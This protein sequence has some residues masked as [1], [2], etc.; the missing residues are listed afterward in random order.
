MWEDKNREFVWISK[1]MFYHYLAEIT[2]PHLLVEIPVGKRRNWFTI[3]DNFVN[4]GTRCYQNTNKGQCSSTVSWIKQLVVGH[5]S[6]S[7][8]FYPRSIHVQSMV[9]KIFTDYFDSPLCIMPPMINIHISFM[10]HRRYII[11]AVESVV[12]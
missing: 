8:G 9:D 4:T 3:A 2:L 7:S 6:R 5:L 10:Y 11:L 12:K 1:E